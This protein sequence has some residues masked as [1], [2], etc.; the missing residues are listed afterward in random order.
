MKKF[1]T[2]VT[3]ICYCSLGAFAIGIDEDE[4]S[5][6]I[7]AVGSQSNRGVYSLATTGNFDA[8]KLSGTT[9]IQ[10]DF[11]G[12][13]GTFTDRA[14]LYGT[15]DAGFSIYA[16]KATATGG[17][18]GPWSHNVWTYRSG[19]TPLAFDVIATDMTY[20][21]VSGQIYGWFKAD[22]DGTKYHLAIYDG[23]ARTAT[24]VGADSKT[25][26]TAI[27]A[28]AQGSLWGIAGAS[29]SLYTI[30]KTDGSLTLQGSLGCV[31]ADDEQSAAID[32]TS[33][34]LYWGMGT[35]LRK[36]DCKTLVATKLYDYANGM[37]FNA[38]YI[39]EPEVKKGA[40]AEVTD[41]HG[42]FLGNGVK[43]SFTAPSKSVVG[44]ALTGALTYTLLLDGDALASGAIAAGEAYSAIHPMADGTHTIA[45]YCSNSEG[46]GPRTTASVYCGYD[47]PG[48]VRSLAATVS[49]SS[50]TL[51]WDM[52]EGENGGVINT[53]TITFNVS[54]N[55][56]NIAT[57]LTECTFTD[58]LPEAPI[59]EYVYAVAVSGGKSAEAAP[60]LVG[61]AHTVPYCE[62]FD[63]AESFAAIAYAVI[64]L[65]PASETWQITDGRAS[66]KGKYP[67]NRRDYLI[68]AP[69]HMV[70]GTYFLSFDARNVSWN[71]DTALDVFISTTRSPEGI[72][73]TPAES[74]QIPIADEDSEFIRY[75][76]PFTV[77]GE[78]DY[79]IGFYDHGEWY[80]ANR[81]DLDNVSITTS[82]AIA[83][84]EAEGTADT[85]YNLQG[86]R[87]S[88]PRTG[89][90]ISKGK[91][92]KL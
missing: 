89:I 61:N 55:G 27:A 78:G 87:V 33:G 45:V 75:E 42:E 88:T 53:G 74:L 12:S 67:N 50:V 54:R 72:T 5:V 43:V 2:L 7:L 19:V 82:S 23:E 16:G 73:T 69:I 1:F 28:D 4:A 86:R 29:G 22:K 17:E 40:P 81:V 60:V 48:A 92:I 68:S 71:H 37:K 77:T 46:N 35:E 47:S 49:G 21:A 9:Y 84:I 38:F 80:T 3:A 58:V 8:T 63:S 76:Y 11:A 20:D 52:P 51:S 30:N 15:R 56:T 85:F 70:P 79:H 91:K 34:T 13:A 65:D 59:A 14:T 44:S 39:A 24:A 18:D 25:K 66:I 26:I 31:S 10:Y 32:P 57:A 41:L 64:D 83:E 6:R 36:I 62:T 90:V